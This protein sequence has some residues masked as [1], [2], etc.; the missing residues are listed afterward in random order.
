MQHRW[1]YLNCT[2]GIKRFSELLL[3]LQKSEI[4]SDIADTQPNTAWTYLKGADSAE[5]CVI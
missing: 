1:R 5:Q 4:N 2:W 3:V